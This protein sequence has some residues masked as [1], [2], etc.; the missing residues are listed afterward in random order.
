M[1]ASQAV[2]LAGGRGTRLRE[3]TRNTPKPL[4]EVGGRPFLDYLIGYLC[5]FG[6]KEIVLSTVRRAS[7]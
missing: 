3:K 1:L 5:G 2:I 7:Y 4:L 6:V